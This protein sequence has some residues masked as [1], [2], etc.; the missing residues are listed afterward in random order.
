[1]INT[2]MKEIIR[3]SIYKGT[4]ATGTLYRIV[5]EGGKYRIQKRAENTNI[6]CSAYSDDLW[7]TTKEAVLSSSYFQNLFL[8]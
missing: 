4:T 2:I 5:E 6:W 3:F 8:N 1:M 7:F